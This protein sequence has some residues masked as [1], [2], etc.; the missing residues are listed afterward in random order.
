MVESPN[1]GSDANHTIKYEV[2]MASLAIYTKTKVTKQD[3]ELLLNASQWIHV[4]WKA[5]SHRR[6]V[7]SFMF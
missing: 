1:S 2:H 4:F 6:S 3:K 5:L 7:L